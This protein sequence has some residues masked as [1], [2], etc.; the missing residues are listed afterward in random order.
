M[1]SYYKSITVILVLSC[2]IFPA[3]AGITRIITDMPVT[4][5]FDSFGHTGAYEKITGTVE[6]E[7]DPNDRRHRDIVD[8]DIAP[9]TN[10]KVA[11]R[12]PFYILRPADPTKANG[13][14]FYAVGNRGAKRALQWLN[15]AE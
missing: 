3:Q 8:I 6:G 11:Y 15:D 2:I 14:I 1:Y 10:G 4:I 13:R 7:I 9:T 12:A 5:E